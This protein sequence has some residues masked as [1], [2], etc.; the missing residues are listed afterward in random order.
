MRFIQQRTEIPEPI[1]MESDWGLIVFV[2]C[3]EPFDNLQ[4]DLAS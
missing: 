2:E 1:N 4:L 3:E